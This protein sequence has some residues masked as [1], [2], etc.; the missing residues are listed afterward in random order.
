MLSPN[1]LND[2]LVEVLIK[3][4]TKLTSLLN[5]KR[6]SLLSDSG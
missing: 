6:P 1:V 2:A 4:K 5:N 3:M